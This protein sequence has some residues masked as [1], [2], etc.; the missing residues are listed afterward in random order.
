[1][2]SNLADLAIGQKA[3]ISV[4]DCDS[5]YAEKLELMGLISGAV[6]TVL[7]AAP[8]GDPI[9]VGLRGYTLSLRRAEA[10]IVKL[11]PIVD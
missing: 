3:R 1:M 2:S 8:L 9:Q 6:I 11:E 4:I 5:A 7:R 10:D